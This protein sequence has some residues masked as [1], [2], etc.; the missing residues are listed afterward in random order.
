MMG[1]GKTTAIGTRETLPAVRQTVGAEDVREHAGGSNRL[2]QTQV[3]RSD[4]HGSIESTQESE[5]SDPPQETHGGEGEN[6]RTL[7][8]GGGSS[9]ASHRRERG[10]QQNTERDDAVRQLP[11][12]V[13]LGA[14][15]ARVEAESFLQR[16]RSSRSKSWLLS[17]ALIPLL[18]VWRSA[19]DEGKKAI[20]LRVGP[21]LERRVTSQN[22]EALKAYGNAIVPQVAQVIGRAILAAEANLKRAGEQMAAGNQ[23]G[24]VSEHD[25]KGLCASGQSAGEP[26]IA[27]R[28]FAADALEAGGMGRCRF[29]RQE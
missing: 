26:A 16:L 22:R 20:W 24:Q 7:R 9:A 10:K 25:S 14:R 19:S 11:R 12:S 15:E 27:P 8:N 28:P 4:L 21:R 17:E 5:L 3:L 13:A 1:Y 29:G 2:Q 18:E 23:E 6:L